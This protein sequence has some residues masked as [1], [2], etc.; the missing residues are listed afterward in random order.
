MEQKQCLWVHGPLPRPLQQHLVPAEP[1]AQPP[2]AARA[3]DAPGQKAIGSHL[4]SPW[5]LSPVLAPL[6][7]Q[8]WRCHPL[9]PLQLRLSL[10]DSVRGPQRPPGCRLPTRSSVPAGKSLNRFLG[11][12]WELRSWRCWGFWRGWRGGS[13]EGPQPCSCLPCSQVW[14]THNLLVQPVPVSG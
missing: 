3:R 1:T 9:Q 4:C 6:S 10:G 2:C 7:A 5:Q 11:K 12:T 14:G 13:E 8:S